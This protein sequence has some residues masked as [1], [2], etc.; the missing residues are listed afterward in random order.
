[1]IEYPSIWNHE[2]NLNSVY[3]KPSRADGANAAQRRADQVR[4]LASHRSHGPTLQFLWG[5]PPCDGAPVWGLSVHR[6]DEF[7]Q[8]SERFHDQV[9]Q[10]AKTLH[11]VQQVRILWKRAPCFCWEPT[12]KIKWNFG[13]YLVET[14]E[15]EYL[16]DPQIKCL[17]LKTKGH[18]SILQWDSPRK[19]HNTGFKT[20]GIGSARSVHSS[21]SSAEWAGHGGSGVFSWHG[22]SNLL[23]GFVEI[24][25]CLRV[26]PSGNRR[27]AA[28][29]GRDEQDRE[30]LYV[31][32]GI[33]KDSAVPLTR[34]APLGGR[35][36]L[37]CVWLICLESRYVWDSFWCL[38][39]YVMSAFS[40]PK[41]LSL[42]F[43]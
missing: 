33:H 19:M 41:R 6:N 10:L 36:C 21:D 16:S 38:S 40:I 39:P 5:P 28:L 34:C 18:D 26:K 29:F 14:V 20:A 31:P 43:H 23:E 17:R 12:E 9:A 4:N 35:M 2:L 13:L 3:Y 22:R 32:D 15:A 27:K 1:M 8:F 37:A 25:V 30:Q 42:H 7:H 11:Q 24:H